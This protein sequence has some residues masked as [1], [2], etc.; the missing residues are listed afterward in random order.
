M[1]LGIFT[2]IGVLIG[3]F[4]TFLIQF[5]FRREE[6]KWEQ[7]CEKKEAAIE[8]MEILHEILDYYD[9]FPKTNGDEAYFT[10]INDKV[11]KSQVKLELHF[12]NDTKIIEAFKEANKAL[13]SFITMEK[14][15][16]I[17]ISKEA[18]KKI[19]EYENLIMNYFQ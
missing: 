15:E 19:R 17:K 2:L 7:K 16:R 4:I 3:G 12:Y 11:R 1:T 14:G 13:K 8:A 5:Y 6:R 18:R 10:G 9:T